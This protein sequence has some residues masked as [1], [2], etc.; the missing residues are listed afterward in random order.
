MG[1]TI[2]HFFAN[3]SVPVMRSTST[4]WAAHLI[5]QSLYV[6]ATFLLNHY[7]FGDMRPTWKLL[8]LRLFW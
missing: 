6:I 2:C 7:R 4:C 8:A 3:V 1:R 5:P